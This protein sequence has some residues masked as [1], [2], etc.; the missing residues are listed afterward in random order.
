[1]RADNQDGPIIDGR[2]EVGLKFYPLFFGQPEWA[3]EFQRVNAGDFFS[4]R[5]LGSL[6]MVLDDF[7][8]HELSGDEKQWDLSLWFAP[9]GGV[10][11]DPRGLSL[12]IGF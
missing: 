3:A 10:A 8:F 9:E 4:G 7:C 11:C 1:M 6:P 2:F 5:F 12:C